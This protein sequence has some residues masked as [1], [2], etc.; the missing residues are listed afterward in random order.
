M[1][2]YI[3]FLVLIL[4][5]QECT[6]PVKIDRKAGK[7]GKIRIEDDGSYFNVSEVKFHH[8]LTLIKNRNIRVPKKFL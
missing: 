7:V 6:K 4:L 5:F 8:L 1:L 2:Q 3:T